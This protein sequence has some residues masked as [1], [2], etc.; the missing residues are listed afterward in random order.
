MCLEEKL[1]RRNLKLISLLEERQESDKDDK[2]DVTE[3][4]VFSS[5]G[6]EVV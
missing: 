2:S 1:R 4:V 6:I 5:E 3:R